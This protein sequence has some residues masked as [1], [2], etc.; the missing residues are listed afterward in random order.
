MQTA[1]H[2][3]EDYYMYEDKKLKT[4]ELPDRDVGS[5][6]MNPRLEYVYDPEAKKIVVKEIRLP[7]GLAQTFLEIVSNA[8]DNVS[9]SKQIKMRCSPVEITMDEKI[10]TV[11]NYG[12]PIPIEIHPNYDMFVPQL[13]FGEL[14]SGSNFKKDVIRNGCGRNGLGAKLTNIFSKL[15]SI[16]CENADTKLQYTQHWW[17]IA[18][19]HTEPEID[20]F[21]GDESSVTVRYELDF[22]RFCYEEYDNEA[23]ELFMRYAI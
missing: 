15:F 1:P 16:H 8:V 2:V 19:Q 14:D 21:E 6:V 3:V 23:L 12:P 18:R 22:E 11:K 4:Y 10:I 20:K 9:K 17:D 7:S 13:I 5:M